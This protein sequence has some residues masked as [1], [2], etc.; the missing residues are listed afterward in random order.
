MEL[1]IRF[2]ADKRKQKLIEEK[3]NE[4]KELKKELKETKL[5]LANLTINLNKREKRNSNVHV[6]KNT[7]KKS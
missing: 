3:D 1:V 4:I 6:K 5:A 7:R 2:G